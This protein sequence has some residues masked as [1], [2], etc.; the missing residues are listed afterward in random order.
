MTCFDWFWCRSYQGLLS[1]IM[2]SCLLW[3][4]VLS[5]CTCWFHNLVTFPSWPVSTGFGAGHIRIPCLILLLSLLLL[6]LLLL[7]TYSLFSSSLC[8]EAFTYPRVLVGLGPV[9]E[10]RCILSPKV[11]GCVLGICVLNDTFIIAPPFVPLLR[12]FGKS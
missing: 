5:V 3:R 10:M 2:M 7:L 9:K 12:C 8:W 11:K 4:I 1:R 6:L